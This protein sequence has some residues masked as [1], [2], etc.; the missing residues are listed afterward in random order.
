MVGCAGVPPAPPG[1]APRRRPRRRRPRPRPPPDLPQRRNAPAAALALQGIRRC[2]SGGGSSQRVPRRPQRRH[3]ATPLSLA[4]MGVA[5][6]RQ[7]R[8]GAGPCGRPGAC[9]GGAI[10]TSNRGSPEGGMEWHRERDKSPVFVSGTGSRICWLSI[11]KNGWIEWRM[12]VER[13]TWLRTR[14]SERP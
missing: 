7:F 5:A 3:A 12:V 13:A 4:G 6:L 8:A 1:T 9:R 2:G 14:L 11:S 10:R